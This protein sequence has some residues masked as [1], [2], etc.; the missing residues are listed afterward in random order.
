MKKLALALLTAGVALSAQAHQTQGSTFGPPVR[1]EI[2]FTGD[3][4]MFDSNLGTLTD[5][6]L[7]L[8]GTGIFAYSGSNGAAQV[9]QAKIT[10]FSDIL[11]SSTLGDLSAFLAGDTI[12]LS[13]TSGLESYEAGQTHSFGPETNTDDATNDLGSILASLSMAGGGT[14]DLTCYSLSGIAVQG[15][16]DN[17]LAA[18]DT[19]VACGARITY[20]RRRGGPPAMD[21]ANGLGIANQTRNTAHFIC[22]AL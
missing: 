5:A 18:Q 7:D 10:V 4:P 9:Q 19:E 6:T 20:I 8:F 1:T 11:W 17:F 14:F 21:E 12:S 15:G 13:S 3:L 2:K 16:G 22:T